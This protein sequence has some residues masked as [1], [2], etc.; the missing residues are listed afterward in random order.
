[1]SLQPGTRLGNYE[2]LSELGSGGMGEVYK[3]RDLKLGREVAIKVL[4]QEMASDSQRL[5]RFE[6]EARAASALNH[7]NIVTIYEI[8]E[9]E[10]TPYIAMEYVEGKTLREIVTDG[11]LPN[12]KLIRY[13]TQMA[14]GLAKAH[15][16]GIVHRDLKPENIVISV[17]GYV[18]I[19]DFGLAKLLPEGEVGAELSTLAKE[20]TPG[21]I[22]G[23]VGY[24]SPEQ[25]KG[26]SA[27]FRSDQFSLGAIVYEMATGKRAFD[28]ESATQTLNA[29]IEDEPE[30]LITLNEKVPA[31]VPAIVERCMAKLPEERYASTRDLARE[32][33]SVEDVPS[34][35]RSR[36]AFLIATTGLSAAFIA[37]VVGLNVGGLRQRL[38]D[39]ATAPAKPSVAVL[40]FQ[41]LS[42]DAENEYFSDGMT[43]EIISKLSRIQSLQV[44][45]RTSVT[46]FKSTTLDVKDVGEELGVR[47]LL[48]GSVRKAGNRVRITA[49]L[50]DC[51]SGFNL[52]S[53]DF[54]GELKDV[55][56][57]Q[58][59]TALKIAE[60]LNLQLSPQETDAVGRHDTEN[61][62]A[63]DAYL[64]ASALSE[65]CYLFGDRRPEQLEAA[66]GHFEQALAFDPDYPLALARLSQIEFLF[67][68]YGVEGT[69]ETLERADEL[70][71]RALTIDPQL[72][73]AHLAMGDVHVARGDYG[74]AIEE[75]QQAL[76][77]DAENPYAWCELAFA[78]NYREPP[79]AVEAEKAAREAVRL[80]PNWNWAHWQ[81]G[82][83]LRIQERYR[84]S[85][86]A[87][88]DAVRVDP[89]LGLGYT[90]LGE[91]HLDQGNYS[92]ALARFNEAR[93]MGEPPDLL[94]YIS[95]A[96]AGDGDLEN[97]LAE[98]ENAFASGYRDVAAIDANPHFAPLRDDPRFQDLLRRMNFPE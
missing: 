19:L 22:L 43:E 20:T 27:D 62:E 97:S 90:E 48:E 4:P 50:I 81:L 44:A 40:P 51:S 92:Q 23:T 87:F 71:S 14:E 64:R 30:P 2:V 82:K 36:R 9:H 12:D 89:G 26:E 75:Y 72:A 5:R 33:R 31:H 79:D 3:A 15:Q 88:E 7:P 80:R 57:V 73:E 69:P 41:N 94:V 60:A 68:Y 17:D 35:R 70:A 11:P 46:R 42:P 21:T 49:Q 83:A 10:G 32:L 47:Y 38:L 8:G 66:R 95:A 91:I 24:M 67:Y 85:I 45:S 37:V 76:R 61:P 58:E 55:F 54:D 18:K 78:H 25:A 34:I 96:Y 13:A 16:A 65:S 84:E 93:E 56:A 86:A 59:Q 28:R 52:W 53:E 74:S 98:L 77:L 63:Y 39:V 1:M 6:Q 29:I